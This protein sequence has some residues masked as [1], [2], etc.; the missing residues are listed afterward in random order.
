MKDKKAWKR[1]PYI[2]LLLSL[3]IITISL[4]PSNDLPKKSWLD[5]PGV[6]KLVHILMYLSLT[7]TFSGETGYRRMWPAVNLY[8]IAL[9]A[10]SLSALMELIQLYFTSSRSGDWF[11]LLANFGGVLL[12]AGLSALLKNLKYGPFRGFHETHRPD[13]QYSE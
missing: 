1:F 2:T 6:D 13:P 4:L 5:F 7:L 11:D 9:Y 8:I 12:G 3:T 10:F